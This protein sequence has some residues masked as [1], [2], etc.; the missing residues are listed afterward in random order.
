MPKVRDQLVIQY[1][2][3]LEHSFKLSM[4]FKVGLEQQFRE[5]RVVFYC[6]AFKEKK[7]KRELGRRMQSIKNLLGHCL[8]L[9]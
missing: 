6:T 3:N 2:V 7:I 4:V 1:Q 8:K 9:I 5:N